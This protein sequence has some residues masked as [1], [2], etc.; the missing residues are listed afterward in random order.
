MLNQGEE[1]MENLLETG[2]PRDPNSIP[3]YRVALAT[4]N[5]EF[6]RKNPSNDFVLVGKCSAHGTSYHGNCRIE[7]D[8]I[9]NTFFTRCEHYGGPVELA[10]LFVFKKTEPNPNA[11]DRNEREQIESWLTGLPLLERC[12]SDEQIEFFTTVAEELLERFLSGL[13]TKW[14]RGQFEKVCVL[15]GTSQEQR[16]MPAV[17]PPPQKQ[18]S[19]TLTAKLAEHINKDGDTTT[20]N[21]RAC[22]P[23]TE[24]GNP[25]TQTDISSATMRMID[26]FMDTHPEVVGDITAMLEGVREPEEWARGFGDRFIGLALKIERDRMQ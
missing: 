20:A 11:S 1:H 25:T 21:D 15:L 12:S 5:T 18:A 8:Q 22:V 4:A 2:N 23:R 10:S 24:A 9:N 16:K 26:L 19:R 13:T 3:I 14:M 6:R 17:S 7:L